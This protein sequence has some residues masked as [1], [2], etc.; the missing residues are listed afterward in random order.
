MADKKTKLTVLV[1]KPVI[2]SGDAAEQG[3]IVEVSLADGYKLIRA[4]KAL[5]ASTDEAKAKKVKLDE[6]KKAKA[7]ADKK[8]QA[9][10]KAQ[11]K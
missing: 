2:I 3:S 11:A 9:D 8:A 1:L 5:D 7:E 10:S 6:A 4:G